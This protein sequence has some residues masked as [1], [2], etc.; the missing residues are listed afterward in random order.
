MYHLRGG[1]AREGTFHKVT[2][3]GGYRVQKNFPWRWNPHIDWA[4]L[5]A[6]WDIHYPIVTHVYHFIYLRFT[7]SHG[8]SEV[9]V[10]LLKIKEK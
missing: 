10:T 3:W 9:H 2:R 1:A 8:L 4:F 7:V 6:E 5:M